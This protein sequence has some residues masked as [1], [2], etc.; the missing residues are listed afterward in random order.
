MAIIQVTDQ[1]NLV[2]TKLFPYASWSFSTLNPVQS[3]VYEFYDKNVNALIASRTSSGKTCIAEMMLSYEIRVRGGKGLYLA[4]MRALAQEKID[5]WTDLK[6]HFSD[7]KIAI[8]TGDYRL[9]KDRAQ[10]LNEADLIIMTTEMLN[11]CCRNFEAEKNAF[12][13]QIG[14]VVI[15]EAHLLTVP[16]RGDHLEVGLMKFT[17]INPEA[18]FL[19]LSATLP[20]VT[21]IA[22]WVGYVLTKRDTMVLKSEYRPCAL[23]VHYE[24]YY[25]GHKNYYDN[26]NEKINYALEIV[27]HY[28]DDKFLVFALSRD[29]GQKM[30]EL[31]NESGI[32]AMFHNANLEKEKRIEIEQKFKNDKKL[33]VIVSTPTLAWGCCAAGT[34]V[35]MADGSLKKIENIVVG[36]NVLASSP[37]GMISKP[38]LRVGPT[39]SKKSFEVTLLTGEK[40]IVSDEHKFLAAIK[41]DNID[42]YEVNLLSVGDYVALPAPILLDCYK[43]IESDDLGYIT[44]YVI[45]DGCKTVCGTFAD[46]VDKIALDIAF[47]SHEVEHANYVRNLMIKYF[48]Y[49][50]GNLKPDTNNVLHLVTKQRDIVK[51]IDCLKPGRHKD[52]FSLFDLSNKSPKFIKGVLQGL[53]DTDGG[54]SAHG[55]KHLSIEFTTISYN[56]AVEVQQLLL[57]FGV[58]SA[59]GKKKMK[60]TIINGRFQPARREWI[61]RVRIY[62]A[63]V[64]SFIENV[65]FKNNVKFDYGNYVI[66]NDFL[67]GI[68]E[69]DIIPARKLLIEHADANNIS[70]RKM[71]KHVNLCLWNSLNKQ[72]LKRKTVQLILDKF[73]KRSKLNELMESGVRFSKIKEIRELPP[74]DMFDIEVAGLH[75]YVSG[76]MISHNCNLPARR[77]V[78]MGTNRGPDLIAYYDIWQMAGRSGRVG[79]DPMGDVYILL[80]E[81]LQKEEKSRIQTPINITSQL[82]NKTGGDDKYH[83]KTLAFHLVNEIHHGEITTSDGVHSW[84]KRSLAHFQ[85]HELSDTVVDTTLTLLKKC[86]AIW[87]DEDDNLTVTAIGQIS[88]L[89]Y[90]S[91]FDVS[92]LK[93][94]FTELFAQNK[95]DNDYWLSM[96]LG[97]IDSHR[98]GTASRAERQEMSMYQDMVRKIM[99][100]KFLTDAAIKIG[101]C[102]YNMINGKS[103]AIV[104]GLQNTLKSDFARVKEVLF[105]LDGMGAKWNKHSY[106]R[107]LEKRIASGIPAHLIDL[108]QVEN[109]GKV[110]AKKLYDAGIKSLKDFVST[111]KEKLG[112]LLNFKANTINE[113]ISKATNLAD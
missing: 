44:G 72:D 78:I 99:P 46:S 74:M 14:T 80:P 37:V 70:T 51:T 91:P 34:P 93:R 17:K 61:Y 35:L 89:F 19:M 12:L 25:D 63:Q 86:G 11:S 83:Y 82:L 47:G 41:R 59:V 13:K 113:L 21:E 103:S 55:E 29:T 84:Y 7:K 95:Q 32:T 22:E 31:L 105:A 73:K 79:L 5:D 101:F 2:E 102:Y 107:T 28:G 81:S 71:L 69:K 36:D 67:S 109:I 110:R 62:S 45:G 96:C 57:F 76:G 108:C 27:E 75:N 16:G 4:P 111:D 9:T 42:Y 40:V 24:T 65:G 87:Q 112:K 26:E 1:P 8:C 56:L 98:F 77:V 49:D 58:K 54:F 48:N 104:N 64:K 97:N 15:D 50:F 52:T 53:F 94:N 33:R 38:I 106:F 43:N 39:R 90:Y 18:R 85:S 10:E 20:N 66:E 68:Q 23:N 92:D 60:D 30:C 100:G 3:R 6:S 88:S